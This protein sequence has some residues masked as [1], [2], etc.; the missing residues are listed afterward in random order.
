MKPYEL[1]DPD[2]RSFLASGA[3]TWSLDALPGIRKRVHATFTSPDHARCQTV[4]TDGL[5]GAQLRLCLY[6]P[7]TVTD[8]KTCPVILY[9]HGGGFVLGQPEMADDYL[10]DLAQHLHTLIVAVDYRLAPEHPFPAPLED[11]YTALAWIFSNHQYLNA[12]TRKLVV[13][14][15]S[16]GGGLAAALAIL[17][18]DRGEYPIMGQVLIYPMLDYRSG[19]AESPFTNVT[20]GKIG[21]QPQANQFCWEALRGNYDLNDERIGYFSP[22]MQQ[23][24]NDLPRTFLSVG[25]LDLF[26]EEN[27]DFA[28]RLSRS[29]VP[30]ELHVYPGAPHMFDQHPG[31]IT[32]QAKLDIERAI[33]R[34]LTSG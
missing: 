2:F 20:T 11:C 3:E 19:S 25:A 6:R 10:A 33:E 16:A 21:W 29:G 14:G 17:A 32:S 7:D 1:L 31:A 22:A 27:V 30:V 8:S 24:L 13:M 34:A 18:R 12:D 5:D 28:R 4:W 26:M 23:D 9:V 15:H